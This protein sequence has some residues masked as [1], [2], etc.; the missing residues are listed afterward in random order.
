MTEGDDFGFPLT[1]RLR[2]KALLR[3]SGAEEAARIFSSPSFLYQ[4]C[5]FIQSK[6]IGISLKAGKVDI[7][8]PSAP[9]SGLVPFVSTHFQFQ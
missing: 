2:Q 9:H 3:S 6:E 8:Q 5:I 1:C 7:P 4:N